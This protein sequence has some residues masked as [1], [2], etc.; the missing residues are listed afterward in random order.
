[1]NKLLAQKSETAIK[2][3]SFISRNSE[4]INQK[5]GKLEASINISWGETDLDIYDFAEE[6]RSF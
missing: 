4:K 2:K 1:M 6:Y 5:F 3:I